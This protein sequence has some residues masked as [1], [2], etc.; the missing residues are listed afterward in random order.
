[1]SGNGLKVSVIVAGPDE[2]VPLDELYNEYAQPLK[3]AGISYEFV[4]VATA[5]Q[6]E[7]LDPLAPLERANEPIVLLESAP[8]VAEAALLRSALPLCRGEVMLLLASDRRVSPE[9]L[10]VLVQAID[11]GADI[12]IARRA[13]ENDA[14]LN[15][16]QRRIAHALVRGLVGGAFSDLG[17]GVRAFRREVLAELP[18]YGEFSRFLPLFASREGFIVQEREVPLHPAAGRTRVYP[19]GVYLRRLVDLFA[20]FFLIRF[21][22]KPLR[23]FGLAGSVVSL[24]GMVI[25]GILGWQRL[26]GQALADR[27]ML[28]VA[29][30]LVVLGAQSVAL[31]LIGEIVVHAGAKRRT[32]YRLSR[33]KGR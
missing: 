30:L 13:A 10:P 5:D 25:M 20:V 31:G 8:R 27:P 33:P 19:P 11:E 21:R 7:H 23:F 32:V 2:T 18:L 26:A 22:E 15:R 24:T 17:S 28:V 29:V 9:A 16:M 1:M 12:V 3:R 14:M 6:R 4:F